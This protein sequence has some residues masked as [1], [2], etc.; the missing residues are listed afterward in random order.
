MYGSKNVWFDPLGDISRG[1]HFLA[2]FG[3][4]Y[5]GKFY[6]SAPMTRGNILEQLNL[7]HIQKWTNSGSWPRKSYFILWLGFYRVV[8]WYFWAKNCFV[9]ILSIELHVSCYRFFSQKKRL[10]LHIPE[11]YK[12]LWYQVTFGYL[13]GLNRGQLWLLYLLHCEHTWSGIWPRIWP[14]FKHFFQVIISRV[15]W[16]HN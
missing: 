8:T 3:G 14:V 2:G 7:S 10:N 11:L 12:R 15:R 4:Q 9:Y 1:I 16:F 13:W 6:I 5:L